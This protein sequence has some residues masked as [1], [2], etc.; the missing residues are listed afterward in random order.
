MRILRKQR[1]D[2][3]VEVM[4]AIVIL[5]SALGA[6][7]AIAN[8]STISTQANHERTQAQLYANEQAEFIKAFSAED[9]ANITSINP[10]AA[11]T[12]CMTDASSTSASCTK[13][14]YTITVRPEKQGP[15]TADN[16]DTYFILVE[17]DSLVNKN[18]R[19]RVELVYG[20]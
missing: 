3:I 2:T 1:G 17:W 9:R 13:G 5:G 19:D 7:F 20:L 8:R 6:A 11:N 14:I 4:I 16:S 10:G 12:F 18:T 15:I